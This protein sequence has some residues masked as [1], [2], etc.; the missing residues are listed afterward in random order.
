MVGGVVP[1]SRAIAPIAWVGALSKIGLK[2]VPPLVVIQTPPAAAPIKTRPGVVGSVASALIRPLALN[3]NPGIAP[4]K[5]GRASF[6][7]SGPIKDQED[8]ERLLP[9]SAPKGCASS[10]RR[11]S[12]TALTRAPSGTPRSMPR[13]W[14][15]YRD[16]SIRCWA[17]SGSPTPADG[18]IAN[19]ATV[20]TAEPAACARGELA[21][22]TRAAVSTTAK[23]ATTSRALPERDDDVQILLNI[24]PSPFIRNFHF[25]CCIRLSLRPLVSKSEGSA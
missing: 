21:P 15:R 22:V 14:A 19:D 3:F 7:G 13:R 20:P 25:G 9:L 17:V 11:I 12:S 4:P 10:I 6:I 2:V 5:F 1:V 8:G 16:R 23:A 24:L 18:S